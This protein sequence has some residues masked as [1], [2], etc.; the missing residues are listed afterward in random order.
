MIASHRPTRI[1]IIREEGIPA[2]HAILKGEL[3]SWCNAWF[4]DGQT[5]TA[6]LGFLSAELLW[7]SS[8]ALDPDLHLCRCVRPGKRRQCPPIARVPTPAD[9]IVIRHV[10]KQFF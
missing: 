8:A 4:L 5:I 3:I 1:P 2:L 9:K 7:T 10:I 6:Q